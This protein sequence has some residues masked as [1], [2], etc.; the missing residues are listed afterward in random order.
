[1]GMSPRC[2]S[3]NT[4]RKSIDMKKGPNL[5]WSLIQCSG[6][7]E[8]DRTPDLLTASQ[9]LSQLSYAPVRESTIR[10]LPADARTILEKILRCVERRGA[11]G[12]HDARNSPR[13]APRGQRQARRP[14]SRGAHVAPGA[15]GQN[16]A[17]RGASAGGF[18]L[19]PSPRLRVNLLNRAQLAPAGRFINRPV[20]CDDPR[21]SDH[22]PTFAKR[23]GILPAVLRATNSVCSATPNP[24]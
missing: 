5:R 4:W 1:M 14:P 20:Y 23:A 17:I 19:S 10:E 22:T 15:A 21:I 12:T 2:C 11:E 16:K 9:A 24:T 13:G 3:V 7:D 6:G 18:R 8:G